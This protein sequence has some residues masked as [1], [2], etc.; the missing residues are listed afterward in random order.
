MSTV[1]AT[2]A[3]DAMGGDDAP[4]VVLEGV[5]AA[6]RSD[7]DLA[8]LLVG[9]AEVVASFSTVERCTPVVATEV[10]GMAE[11]AAG[12][13]RACSRMKA[14]SAARPLLRVGDRC[15]ASPIAAM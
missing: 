11:H 8:V 15:R 6:L 7:P 12:A 13:V 9:P 2:V 1:S 4:A 10:I 5:S 14:S 3:V